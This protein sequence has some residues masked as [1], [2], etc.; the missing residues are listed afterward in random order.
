MCNA[1]CAAL[2]FRWI[3]NSEIFCWRRLA[4][5]CRNAAAIGIVCAGC[6]ACRWRCVSLTVLGRGTGVAAT[7]ADSALGLQEDK[8]AV[9]L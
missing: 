3:T 6:V 9:T 2:L 1:A 5:G 4:A 8:S 7:A